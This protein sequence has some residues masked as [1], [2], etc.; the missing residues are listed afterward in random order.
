MTATR[1]AGFSLV[2]MLVVI[3][4]V[5]LLLGILLPAVQH[6][7][8]AANRMSCLSNLRQVGLALHH[9]EDAHG[10]LPPVLVSFPPSGGKRFGASVSWRVPLLP[11]LE[12]ESLWAKT[13][14]AA[15]RDPYSYH[16][17][18]HEGL[19]TVL[20]VF[21]CPADARLSQPLRDPVSGITAAYC[22]Y[23]G[24][25]GNHPGER[26]NP[27]LY[28][29]FATQNGTRF[30]EILDGTSNTLA[31]GERPPPSGL[32]NGWWYSAAC[33]P[34][35][36]GGQC[37]GP[38]PGLMMDVPHTSFYEGC[39][40]PFSYGPGRLDNPCDRFHFW[41]LHSGGAN[42]LFADG[43]ARFI[44]Y[45]A[46]AVMPALATRAGGETQ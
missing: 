30:A 19:A 38:A 29:V 32:E 16:N 13:V 21:N 11:Y 33:D 46:K 44:S 41:S 2:E 28:G 5:G 8:A 1:R 25:E 9:Y 24:V 23:L 37:R 27:R 18:P 20:R 40:G 36:T 26:G 15:R 7:R 17:P 6:V 45:G 3:G 4:L 22:S 42:F 31:V 14:Q 12:Q 10:S 34:T 39:F 35:E 43:S